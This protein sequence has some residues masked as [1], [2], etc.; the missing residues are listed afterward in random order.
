MTGETIKRHI[1]SYLADLQ[2][3]FIWGGTLARVIHD[4]TGHK[5][6]IVERRARELAEA[7]RIER[8][9][10]QVDGKGPKCVMFKYIT[11]EE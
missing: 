2:G 8:T 6:A 4:R 10:Q 9:Y 11:H 5:E 3:Q 1:I 7:G